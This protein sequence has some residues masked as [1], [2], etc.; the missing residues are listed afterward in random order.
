MK[1]RR[2][3]DGMTVSMMGILNQGR[4]TAN[5]DSKPIRKSSLPYPEKRRPTS[6]A[7]V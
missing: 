7:I 6:S 5:N 3:Q 2:W 4:I 1:S